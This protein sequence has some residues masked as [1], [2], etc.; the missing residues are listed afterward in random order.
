MDE[1]FL[2]GMEFFGRHGVMPE[3]QV[4]GQRFVVHMRMEGDY[5]AAS[6][7]DELAEAVDYARVFERVRERV[8][9]PPV[10]LLERLAA[11]IAQDVLTDWP[12][13]ARVSVQVD[14]PG[15]PIAGVFATAG[16]RVSRTRTD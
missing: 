12:A 9:G 6:E 14:K 7:S 11:L 4:L 5:R 3:E 8:E 15:A 10:R 13:V 2:K 16:V 1:V